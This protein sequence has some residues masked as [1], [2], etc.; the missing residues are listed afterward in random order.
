[1]K[2]NTG[3]EITPIFKMSNRMVCHNNR[4]IPHRWEKLIDED[5]RVQNV[6]ETE[7]I[8][9]GEISKR[10]VKKHRYVTFEM[11]YAMCRMMYNGKL[12]PTNFSKY[13][14]PDAKKK[15]IAEATRNC[16]YYGI[17]PGDPLVIEV[18]IWSDRAECIETG[19]S[20]NGRNKLYDLIHYHENCDL[21]VVWTTS[22]N[23]LSTS[24]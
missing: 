12:I 18:V 11:R 3:N 8:E 14:S 21:Q 23:L 7:H 17:M 20:P 16:G 6:I 15:A 5:E 19:K 22:N 4:Y 2:D 9:G 1:M 10:V 13:C 24:P